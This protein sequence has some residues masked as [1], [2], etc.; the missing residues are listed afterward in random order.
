M[1]NPLVEAELQDICAFRKHIIQSFDK[2]HSHISHV[3]LT[4]LSPL[5]P[6]TSTLTA[7]A[8]TKTTSMTLSTITLPLIP[9]L[10]PL[11]LT[12]R[13][14][15]PLPKMTYG[16]TKNLKLNRLTKTT[17]SQGTSTNTI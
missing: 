12:N 5:L 14:S 11:F 13:L 2:I 8:L 7:T 1:H 17:G 16:I 3:I 4:S 6:S 10:P 9:L 15:T